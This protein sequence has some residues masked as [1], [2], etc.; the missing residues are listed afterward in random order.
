MRRFPLVVLLSTLVLGC[1]GSAP[2]PRLVYVTQ[3]P[4]TPSPTPTPTPT[5]AK[6][7]VVDVKF[8]P[9]V[10]VGSGGYKVPVVPAPSPNLNCQ[11]SIS[12]TAKNLGGQAAYV[13]VEVS[14]LPWL[15]NLYSSPAGLAVQAATPGGEAPLW[16]RFPPL[17]PGQTQDYE[18]GVLFT[19]GVGKYPDVVLRVLSGGA[20]FDATGYAPADSTEWWIGRDTLSVVAGT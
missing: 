14:G 18:V 1:A 7:R 6:L 4:A 3:P 10:Q 15:E 19:S 16:V 11:T 2:T 5:P 12:F 8:I 13:W 17:D 20:G 9:E